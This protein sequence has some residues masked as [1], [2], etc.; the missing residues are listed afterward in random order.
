MV[1]RKRAEADE[2]DRIAALKTALAEEE[3]QMELAK[4]EAERKE[5]HEAMLQEQARKTAEREQELI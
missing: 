2:K 4:R 3:R 1:A 5:A